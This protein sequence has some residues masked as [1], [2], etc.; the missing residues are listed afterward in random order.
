MMKPLLFL[1][2]A[3]FLLLPTIGF[4]Q[5]SCFSEAL[6]S[7]HPVGGIIAEIVSAPADVYAD[8][9]AQDTPVAQ[10]P[11]GTFV[12][13]ISGP[14]CDDENSWWQ[15]EFDAKYSP[16]AHSFGW[17]LA[18]NNSVYQIKPMVSTWNPP[19][20]T[21]LISSSNLSELQPLA[22]VGPFGTVNQLVWSPNSSHLAISSLWA[23]W[24]YNTV[25][26]STEPI[27][28]LPVTPYLNVH[29]SLAFSPDGELLATVSFPNGDLRLWSLVGTEIQHLETR[30]T[31][32]TGVAAI[33]P[34]ISRWAIAQRDGSISVWDA[35]TGTKAFELIGHNIIGELAFTP[36]GSILISTGNF[37][38]LG[39]VMDNAV[40]L[41]DMTNG[42]L[43]TVV[44][45]AIPSF[46]GFTPKIAITPDGQTAAILSYLK[47]EST[48]VPTTTLY[49]IDIAKRAVREQLTLSEGGSAL[50][51]IG[52]NSTGDIIALT[53][54]SNVV[55]LDAKN[56]TQLTLLPVNSVAQN[57]VLSPNDKWL[58]IA[59]HSPS[60]DR[61]NIQLWGAFR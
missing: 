25:E 48:G 8:A 17:I 58:A 53:F 35:K 16:D 44:E 6:V 37:P 56:G 7:S 22:E 26:P 20:N 47:P 23:V 10:L 2:S 60:F 28:L 4:G 61:M 33:A 11:P 50:K 45:L 42:Q 36:D 14:Q 34:D 55:L 51:E 38:D 15:V 57:I 9:T 13:I 29:G 41:W 54:E 39:T 24:V 32:Y 31:D 30:A 12:Y 3:V 40:R 46:D 21:A 27:R 52:F 1:F 49:L 43:L 19:Q 5:S 59:Y 18:S